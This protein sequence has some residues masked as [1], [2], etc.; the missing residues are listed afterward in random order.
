MTVRS[1]IPKM[2]TLNFM[3]N[4]MFFGAVAVPFFIDWAG[5]D[6]TRMFLLEA[7][8][9]FWMF[10][11]E[12][13]TGV[14]ADR[15][16]RKYSLALGGLVS[17]ASFALFGLVNSYAVFF[18]AEFICAVGFTLLSGADRALFY[19]TLVALGEEAWATRHFSRYEIAGTAG[20]IVG[21]LG[22]SYLA[23]S[24]LAPYPG[25]LPMTFIVTAMALL[26]VTALALLLVEPERKKIRERLIRQGIDG[27]TYIFRN[28]RLRGFSLNYTFISA[29]GFFMFWLYQPL[30]K[31]S[32]VPISFNGAAGT[33]FNLLGI[34]L[35]MSIGLVEKRTGIRPLLFLTALVPG[36]LYAGLYFTDSAAYVLPAMLLIVGLRQ[37]RIPLLSDLINRDIESANRATVLSGLSMLERI[38]IMFMYPVTGLLA[39]R[40]VGAACLFLGGAIMVFSLVMEYR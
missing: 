26:P 8:F 30:L 33:A 36:V 1:N 40:S 24:A 39:D 12:V 14:V 17:A 5:L 37:M 38:I 16:G 2:Y 27:F 32:G 4:M 23:G 31:Q 29:A 19:D 11:L 20:I 22:G 3:K 10:V 34:G 25:T 18:A 21:L 9:A 7:S 35:M 28:G 6:Y 13:P 15:Y